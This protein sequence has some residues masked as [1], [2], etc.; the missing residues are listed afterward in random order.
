MDFM[1]TSSRVRFHGMSF[2]FN[3]TQTL[4]PTRFFDPNL[5]GQ[6]M[7]LSL[8][9]KTLVSRKFHLKLFSGSVFLFFSFFYFIIIR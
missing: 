4:A 6:F 8:D 7:C 2:F 3:G 5:K 1:V 9:F